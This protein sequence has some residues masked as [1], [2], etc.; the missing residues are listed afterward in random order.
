MGAAGAA[1][2]AQR[3]AQSAGLKL[4]RADLMPVMVAVFSAHLSE[5]RT[6][7]AAEFIALVADDLAELRAVGFPL[8]R[9]A[10][11]YVSEWVRD[12]ILI[13]RPTQSREE[14]VELSASAA[15]AVRFVLAIDQPRSA[16]NSSRL[17]NVTE[18]LTGLAR[19]TDPDQARRL[20]A[21]IAQRDELDAQIE[22]VTA[23]DSEP[24]N[25]VI[26]NERLREVLRLA[27]E[28]PADFAKVAEDLEQ[29]NHS[30]R[31]QII[32]HDGPRGG[33]LDEVFAGVDVIEQSE[34][35]RTFTAFHAMLAD[36]ALAESFDD[37]VDAILTRDFTAELDSATGAFLRHFM[38]TLQW[39]SGQARQTLTSFSRSLRRFV[40]TQEYREQKR[41]AVALGQAE[42]ATLAALQQL[43]PTQKTG[44]DIDLTSV[45]ISSIGAWVLHNPADVRTS[46][47]VHENQ[48]E[49]L[50]LEV[51]RSQV[52]L[53]EI[54]FHEL[55]AN[56]DATLA[57]ISTATGADVLARFPA[58]QGLASI[59]GLLLLAIE[60]ATPASGTEQWSWQAAGGNT[61]IVSAPRYVFSQP[62]TSGKDG[63]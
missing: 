8:A 33:V 46:T 11:D 35:G 15:D 39:E 58:T 48:T 2:D 31:E 32:N 30:L 4:L 56:I 21:L 23:G 63:R 25:E 49:A 53:T 42:Q 52:R 44:F 22:R 26:A 28:V 36:P 1:Y 57:E 6:R 34:A 47:P 19:D 60:Q 51:L 10:S 14:T 40:E 20:A 54:D 7:P 50:D 27:G 45:P 61:K 62:K 41:L 3:A 29:L 9:S 43:A 17:H 55:Q 59:V 38:T 37:A 16:V 13:R 12:G 24:L 18:L 5:P